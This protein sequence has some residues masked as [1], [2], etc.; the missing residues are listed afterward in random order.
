MLLP[1]AIPKPA[2][3]FLLLGPRGTGKST[4]LARAF[5]GAL[6]IDLLD[7]SR[8]LQLSRSPSS[9]ELRSHAAI[10]GRPRPIFHYSVSGGFDVDFLVQTR[11]KTL[12]APRQLVAIEAKLGTKAKRGW[13]A[14]LAT[15]L[16]ECPKTVRRAI[17]VYQGSDRLVVDGVD[18][19]PA[20][21]FFEELHAGK[22]I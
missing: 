3:T 7:S 8:F 16:R 12:A 13:T 1:R 5:P 9:L 18:V 17:L 15:L 20:A 22:V 6:S 10:S 14:G 2:K 21:T 4:W 19:V 11:A